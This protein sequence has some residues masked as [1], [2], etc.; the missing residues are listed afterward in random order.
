SLMA[1][2]K[3]IP[4]TYQNYNLTV[5]WTGFD[6]I[7]LIDPNMDITISG[8][9]PT[10]DINLGGVSLGIVARSVTIP[11]GINTP[12]LEIN[13]R[14]SLSITHS[15][16]VIDLNLRVFGDSQN[17]TLTSPVVAPQSTQLVAPDGAI[18]LPSGTQF[19]S[20]TVVLKSRQLN[21]PN[22]TLTLSA[23]RLTLVTHASST[24]GLALSNDRSLE[25][26]AQFDSAHMVQ[27]DGTLS[28]VFAGI[29]W[30]SSVAADW[31]DQ[32][33]DGALNPWALVVTGSLNIALPPSTSSEEY[34]LT[35]RGG[36]RSWSGNIRL[37]ADEMDFLGGSSTVIAPGTLTLR[38]TSPVWTYRLGT[39][40]ETGGGSAADPAHAPKMLDFPTSDLAAL[41]D[42][43]T[44]LTIGRPQ[45]GNTMRLGDAFSMTTVKAT[46]EERIIDASIKDPLD[47]LTDVLFVEGDFRVPVDPLSIQANATTIARTNLHTPNN[48]TPDSG[49]TAPSIVLTAAKNLQVGGWIRG[50]QVVDV[51]VADT[52]GDYSLV[53]D[54]GSEIVQTG[55]TG[56]LSV[57]GDKGLRIGGSIRANAAGAVPVLAAATVFEVLGNADL[58]VTGAGSTLNLTAGADIAFALGSVVRAGVT[59]TWDG[60]APAYTVTGADSD[61]AINS[62]N[63]LLLGG[64]VVTSGGLNIT[65]GTN[66]RS[67][68]DEFAAIFAAAP[69]H[70]MATHDRYSILLTGTIAV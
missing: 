27:L 17:I 29:S 21:V 43:F 51:T 60:G 26:N 5:Y 67:H 16:N 70:Y 38:A 65:A 68:A 48:S 59:V 10:S 7:D 23:D 45:A 11:V 39:S 49:L 62:P 22:N 53:M 14:D 31:A 63:E 3:I 2:Q 15:L 42:G 9:T 25:L 1:N 50:S 54:A 18:N 46:G 61:V 69:D 28:S 58:A 4:N 47:L 20:S 12:A 24:N 35:V 64:L 34:G 57:S 19:T 56:T 40:A 66:S 36:L 55:A 30:I 6:Q 44:H 41:A 37:T 32:V 8:A 33:F 13:V 52:V